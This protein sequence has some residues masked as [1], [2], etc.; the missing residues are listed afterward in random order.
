MV[1]YKNAAYFQQSI[2]PISAPNASQ[3]LSLLT[4]PCIAAFIA[5]TRLQR[6]RAIPFRRTIIISIT[7]PPD[8]VEVG[9]C[10]CS[11]MMIIVCG[12]ALMARTLA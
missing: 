9:C 8:Q 2:T 3:V 12:P 11:E 10:C 7:L 5:A 6:T 1:L 4:L